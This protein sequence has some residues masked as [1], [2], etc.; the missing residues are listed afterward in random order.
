MSAAT[1]APTPAPAPA[2]APDKHTPQDASERASTGGSERLLS[3]GSALFG[4]QWDVPDDIDGVGSGSGT[5]P[6]VSPH[7]RPR[8][9]VLV[10]RPQ[11]PAWLR[12]PELVDHPLVTYRKRPQLGPSPPPQ[13]QQRIAGVSRLVVFAPEPKQAATA[14][15]ARGTAAATSMVSVS[16]R[17]TASAASNARPTMGHMQLEAARGEPPRRTATTRA[18]PD[19]RKRRKPKRFEA[20]SSDSELDGKGKK[21]KRREN[22]GTDQ[23][24][25]SV[26][27]EEVDDDDDD[28]V[29]E[30]GEHEGEGEDGNG[31]EASPA[32]T[33]FEEH[34]DQAEES[35]TTHTAP[36]PAPPAPATATDT[37]ARVSPSRQVGDTSG[38]GS[39]ATP[40]IA[41]APVPIR[42]SLPAHPPA[43]H[44]AQ[45]ASHFASVPDRSST[46]PRMRL[47]L[48]GQSR[49]VASTSS[50]P[51]P[52]MIRVGPHA[53]AAAPEPAPAAVRPTTPATQPH[54][55]RP[56]A[57]ASSTPP[58]PSPPQPQAQ[59]QPPAQTPP[60]SAA[61]PEI[62]T[63]QP[64][65]VLPDQ[66]PPA[67]STPTHSAATTGDDGDDDAAVVAQFQRFVREEHTPPLVPV[68]ITTID[69][70]LLD[71]IDPITTLGMRALCVRLMS[72]ADAQR[73]GIQVERV[74]LMDNV[75]VSTFAGLLGPS[76]DAGTPVCAM[77]V[78]SARVLDDTLHDTLDIA[79]RSYNMRSTAVK[80]ILG[81][82]VPLSQLYASWRELGCPLS[83]CTTLPDNEHWHTLPWSTLTPIGHVLFAA[84]PV[85]HAELVRR[86]HQPDD[87]VWLHLARAVLAHARA[88]GAGM[89]LVWMH[90]VPC[91]F[92]Y[93]GDLIE[94]TVRELMVSTLALT[95]DV[96][97]ATAMR[98]RA[99]ATILEGLTRAGQ[100]GLAVVPRVLAA[101]RQATTGTDGAR[102]GGGDACVQAVLARMPQRV[103][104]ALARVAAPGS[105]TIATL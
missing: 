10:V 51:A 16:R 73:L 30:E 100:P 26:E 105:P 65:T 33:E 45:H 57:A 70:V 40:P 27:E 44:N 79:A 38:S 89:P 22:N 43:G 35:A 50:Q 66:T 7:S 56:A 82:H 37:A 80:A 81:D 101:I 18:P 49:P 74:Y 55:V 48:T 2:P 9:N 62:R 91:L 21:S 87:R 53:P 19:A 47:A 29:G 64:Q 13:Q 6:A 1:A 60:A 12:R 94:P 96:A 104:A 90:D 5:S 78:S 39:D 34:H 68:Y 20:L 61:A 71:G 24:E 75:W 28:Y 23:D 36:A 93:H 84:V 4:A 88:S 103:R 52:R 69:R 15:M 76:G 46:Q 17:A 25:S 97:V 85:W 72:A 54:F 31:V 42:L 99:L 11:S 32:T 58:L 59:P 86:Q 41:S 95:A 3:G 98:E 92:A 83:V 14:A 67:H 102:G 8:T 63:Q 77:V